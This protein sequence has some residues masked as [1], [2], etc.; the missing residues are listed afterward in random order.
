M[1]RRQMESCEAEENKRRRFVCKIFRDI[2]STKTDIKCVR[3][4]RVLPVSRNPFVGTEKKM[5]AYNILTYAKFSWRRKEVKC[6]AIRRSLYTTV[7]LF[8][9]SYGKSK[10]CQL[11]VGVKLGLTNLGRNV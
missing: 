1:R 9:K 2:L 8:S 3:S 7:A 10:V 6:S 4:L 11:C 5:S